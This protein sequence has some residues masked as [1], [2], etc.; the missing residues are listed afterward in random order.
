MSDIRSEV[1]AVRE[2]YARRTGDDKYS[3]LRPEVY[4]SSQERQRAMLRLFRDEIG[5]GPLQAVKLVEIG[6]GAGANLLELL[7]LGF[8]PG[9]LLGIELIAE[10]AAR[11]REVL[12]GSLTILDGDATQA[13][14]APA[15]VDIVYQSL[16]FSSLLDPGFQAGLARQ[17]WSWVKP[18][19]GVLWYDFVYD[20]P[21]NP[22]VRGLPVVRVRELFPGALMTARRI[23]LAPPLSRA[24]CRIHPAA[25]GIFNAL[26]FLRTHVLCWLGK[27][28]S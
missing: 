18:G 3:M 24:V 28:Y 10:R 21:A 20:N 15:S 22:D 13:P 9:N 4:L 12:P 17:M 7:R 8:Q 19:G 23:T 2:R 6:C 5:L 14:I 27:R 25:Y 16:V 1:D 11:A 26:P